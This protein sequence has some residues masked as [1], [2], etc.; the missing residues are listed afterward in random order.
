[1]HAHS[2]NRLEPGDYAG[3]TVTKAPPWHGLVAWDMLFNSLTTG[4]FLT[5]AIGDLASPADYSAIARLAYPIALVLLLI[6][7]GCL[8]GDLGDPMRFHYMLRV[9]KVASP[10]SLGTWCLTIY[11][12]PLTVAAAISLLDWPMFAGVRNLASADLLAWLGP[13]RT[14]SVVLALL[15]AFGSAVYKGVLLSTSAQPGWKEARW[16]G[17]YMTSAAAMLGSAMLLAIAGFMDQEHAAGTLRICLMP[18]MVLNLIV[19]ALLAG[20][21]LPALKRRWSNGQIWLIAGTAIGGGLVA[22]LALMPF[23]IGPI[24]AMALVALLLAGSLLVRF[25]IVLLPHETHS[26]VQAPQ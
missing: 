25:V 11:S 14:L 26:R 17:A 18:L 8:I 2:E 4:T 7:L 10:M 24:A 16:L 9:F 12:I 5:A 23:S 15:P 6:D 3:Q 13:V 20:N 19:L 22:P 1:M 21:L